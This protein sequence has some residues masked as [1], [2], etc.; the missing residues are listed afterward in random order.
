MILFKLYNFSNVFLIYIIIPKLL[1]NHI[2]F[3]KKIHNFERYSIFLKLR[4]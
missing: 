2:I 3:F 4:V 1:T